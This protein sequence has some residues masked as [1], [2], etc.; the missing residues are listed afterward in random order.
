MLKRHE[1]YIRNKFDEL[2]ASGTTS[3]EDR[4]LLNAFGAERMGRLKVWNALFGYLPEEIEASELWLFRKNGR[5]TFLHS[6]FMTDVDDLV[7]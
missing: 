4:W 5:S 3:F 7:D 6:D 2:L 1:A